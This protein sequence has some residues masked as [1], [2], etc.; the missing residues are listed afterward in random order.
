MNSAKRK[1]ILWQAAIALML[2]FFLYIT[3]RM[4]F[5]PTACSQMEPA[6]RVLLKAV[7]IVF[8]FT[9]VCLL[10][11]WKVLRKGREEKDDA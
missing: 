4:A 11:P 7:Y 8:F 1:E 2:A 10:V 6:L 9:V 3:G 5:D